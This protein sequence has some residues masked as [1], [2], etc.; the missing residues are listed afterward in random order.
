MGIDE[1]GTLARL[2]AHR[3]ELLDPTIAEHRGRIVKRTGDGILIEF[4]SAVDATPRIHPTDN[5]RDALGKP[6]MSNG[7][8]L[9]G[10]MNL[11]AAMNPMM[12]ATMKARLK[13][14][15]NGTRSSISDGQ[16]T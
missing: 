15:G 8:I 5:R 1:E 12:P 14:R 16:L 11:R 7:L 10:K 2:N 4:S 3:R 13:M 6:G 9:G